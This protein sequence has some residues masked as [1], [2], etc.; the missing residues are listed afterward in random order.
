MCPPENF[1]FF[2]QNHFAVRSCFRCDRWNRRCC[3]SRQGGSRCTCYTST[4]S[5][6]SFNV[7]KGIEVLRHLRVLHCLIRYLILIAGVVACDFGCHISEESGASVWWELVSILSVISVV[8]DLS[9]CSERILPSDVCPVLW[10]LARI[11]KNN[12]CQLHGRSCKPL[13][14]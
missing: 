6:R 5:I 9:L 8:V 3:S 10:A 4:T 1:Q 12:Q 2:S 13:K 14:Y 7:C 11:E